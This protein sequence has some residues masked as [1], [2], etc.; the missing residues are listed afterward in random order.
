LLVLLE[1]MAVV[2]EDREAVLLKMLELEMMKVK[3]LLDKEMMAE[4]TIQQAAEAAVELVPLVLM[5]DLLLEE[6]EELVKF[7]VLQDLL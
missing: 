6:M 1:V 4:I 5:E 3:V 7:L 2:L